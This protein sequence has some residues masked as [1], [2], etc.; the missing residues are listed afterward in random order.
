MPQGKIK[1][2]PAKK[3]AGGTRK[4]A[5]AN[6]K[7]IAKGRRSLKAGSRSTADSRNSKREVTKAIDR[8][9]EGA[10]AARLLASGNKLQLGD[11]ADAGRLEAKRKGAERERSEGKAKNAADRAGNKL[12]SMG[13]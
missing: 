6:K 12:R 11:L 9:N 7:K 1:M 5:Q 4:K 3:S 8:R 10:V 2:G 13:I